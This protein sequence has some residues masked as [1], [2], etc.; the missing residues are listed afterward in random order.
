MKYK[1]LMCVIWFA[2]SLFRADAQ[3]TNVPMGSIQYMDSRYGFRDVRFGMHISEFKEL[4]TQK[5]MKVEHRWTETDS[6]DEAHYT[7][8]PEEAFGPIKKLSIEYTFFKQRLM[9]IEFTVRERL[10]G[11]DDARWNADILLGILREV[12]GK[13]NYKSKG[14]RYPYSSYLYD[15]EWDGKRVHANMHYYEPY[16]IN[17]GSGVRGTFAIKSKEI[18][19]ERDKFMSEKK[20]KEELEH[21]KKTAEDVER[22]A[23][24]L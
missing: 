22:A 21:R 7:R 14:D 11:R 8:S 19:A 23:K 10:D 15:V 2:Q 3:T 13:G 20:V 9:R 24:G 18:Q 5:G 6:S 16:P 1:M 17:Y 12:Y 4:A